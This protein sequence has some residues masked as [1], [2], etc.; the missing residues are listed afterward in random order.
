M[1]NY[2][3]VVGSKFKPYSFEEYIAPYK[4]YDEAYQ[5]QEAVLDKIA[6]EASIWE[7]MIN[8][9][10]DKDLYDQYQAFKQ[11]IESK[12][13]Q[14][15]KYGLN[16]SNRKDII[17]MKSRYNKEIVPIENA[18]K[19]RQQ[20]IDEQRQ[21]LKSDST[22][23]FDI[24]A[25]TLSL[26][27]LIKNQAQT[28]KVQSG[29][30]IRKR[31]AATVSEYADSILK[32]GEWANTAGGKFLERI[33]TTGLTR[34]DIRDIMNN[35][36]KYP[37]IH[38]LVENVIS[39]TG[40]RN[41]GNRQALDNAYDYAYEGLFA[42]MGKKSIDT[43]QDPNYMSDYEIWK[44]EQEKAEAQREE[45]AR[46]NQG[47]DP[48]LPEGVLDYKLIGQDVVVDDDADLKDLQNDLAVIQKYNARVADKNPPKTITKEKYVRNY[49]GRQIL[50]GYEEV[51][52]P[53]L[54]AYKD[55]VKEYSEEDPLNLENLIYQKL[56]RGIK[57]N[58]A[59][60]LSRNDSDLMMSQ[61]R[62]MVTSDID[63]LS[64]SDEVKKYITDSKGKAP[65]EADLDEIF[66]SNSK[67]AYYP[68]EDKIKI[69]SK[70]GNYTLQKEIFGN[71]LV[72]FNGENIPLDKFLTLKT[73]EY[74]SSDISNKEETEGYNNLI[75]LAFRVLNE[76]FNTGTPEASKT[77]S[78]AN[79]SNIEE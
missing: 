76:H 75:N 10:K 51:E 9:E 53:L 18:Y 19:R 50:T 36:N 8:E 26:G 49:E 73:N 68:G 6:T 56:R 28:Y 67:L 42:G 5:A 27:D 43:R 14:L 55:M 74:M 60:M 24:D 54:T 39:T 20:F 41:W 25:S 59:Y 13:E 48:E 16:P 57:K 72:P 64:D 34:E 29:D 17:G 69:I 58:T 21:A 77:S 79:L 47:K 62:P 65:K 44:W 46:Q 33:T 35:P 38:K 30:N 11:D 78:K 7:G 52:D 3:L 45:E 15:S 40:I 22:A 1:A 12:A 37:E 31:V 66:S 4:M 32:T 63:D 23:I 70:K 2:N 71:I 61:L